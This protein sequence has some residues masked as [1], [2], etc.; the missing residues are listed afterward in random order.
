MV[1]SILTSYFFNM[2]SNKIL[3][4]G[5]L[6]PPIG[7]VSIHVSRKIAELSKINF[8][9][10]FINT[11]DYKPFNLFKNIIFYK[12]IHLHVSNVYIQ[13]LFS[14]FFFISRK[15]SFITF[16]GDL[17]RFN[18]VKKCFLLLS[19]FFCRV[20]ILINERSFKL[21][22]K[23]NQNAKLISTFIPP[24]L[25]LEKILEY[26]YFKNLNKFDSIF[27]TNAYNLTYDKNG[28]EIYQI[29]TL[30]EIFIHLPNKVLIISDPSGSY[31]KYLKKKYNNIPDNIIIIPK[32]HNFIEVLIKSDYFIRFTTTDGDSLSINEALYLNKIVITT[33]VVN[34]PNGVVLVNLCK[35]DLLNTIN[36]IKTNN[37]N[38]TKNNYDT[39]RQLV[40]LYKNIS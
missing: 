2:R 20:P 39:I 40:E 9:F 13:L 25:N 10:L 8:P 7:G 19:I 18:N 17:D 35:F 37:F 16:H 15:K 26:E 4:I 24:N 27:C 11:K 12:K 6:P 33:N 23:I 38:I 34:R 5:P 29:S 36:N 30:F 21:A 3:I 31:Y 32:E 14:L 22:N 28:L 1:K